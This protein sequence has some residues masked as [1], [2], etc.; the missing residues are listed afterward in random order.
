MSDDVEIDPRLR[1]NCEQWVEKLM[2]QVQGLRGMVIATADGYEVAASA[3]QGGQTS[4]IAAMASSISALGQVVGQESALGNSQF[5][6]IE[7][8]QGYLAV[9]PVHHS[10]TS[11]IIGIMASK[12]AVAGQVLHFGRQCAQALAQSS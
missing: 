1:K 5:V 10:S 7:A 11:L 3:M 2:S 8:E 12:E 6:L 9:L 4:R